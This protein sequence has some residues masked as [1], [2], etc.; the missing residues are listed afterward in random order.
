[1]HRIERCGVIKKVDN[2]PLFL[3]GGKLKGRGRVAILSLD[4]LA[5]T[6]RTLVGFW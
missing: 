1:M 3:T 5:V 2:V 4:I 6:S